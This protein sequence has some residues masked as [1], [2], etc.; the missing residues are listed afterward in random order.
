MPRLGQNARR[1]CLSVRMCRLSR[2]P[3]GRKCLTCAR[4]FPH[5]NISSGWSM[6][7][8]DLLLHVAVSP[9]P[10]CAFGGGGKG[11]SGRCSQSNHLAKAQHLIGFPEQRERERG[12]GRGRRGLS[13]Q[14]VVK[15]DTTA[16]CVFILHQM[17]IAGHR[18]LTIEMNTHRA[19]N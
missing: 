9:G 14:Q 7:R 6:A 10:I 3:M 13:V 16:G 11:S 17:S 18:I 2:Q 15:L 12:G 19:N 5:G 1:L 4:L 8:E